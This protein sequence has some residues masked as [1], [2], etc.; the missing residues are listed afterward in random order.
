MPAI[1]WGQMLIRAAARHR[2]L[3]TPP[4]PADEPREARDPAVPAEGTAARR[5]AMRVA[6][7]KR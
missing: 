4:R 3:S 5:A 7:Y 2:M 6:H 1:T